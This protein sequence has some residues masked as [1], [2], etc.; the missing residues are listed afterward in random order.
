MKASHILL[1]AV[2]VLAVL[3]GSAH[4]SIETT[5]VHVNTVEI[6]SA[7]YNVY[8]MMVTD[9]FQDWSTCL[10]NVTLTT[11]DFYND[12][13]GSDTQPTAAAIALVPALEWDTYAATPS[14]ESVL[15]SFTLDSQFGQNP[16]TTGPPMG[17]TV[18]KAHW[19]DTVTTGPATFRAARL[20]LSS[21]AAGTIGGW[22]DFWPPGGGPIRDIFDGRYTIIG[23]HIVPEPATLALL[24]LAPLAVLRRRSGQVLRRRRAESGGGRFPQ[25]I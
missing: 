5:F 1:A 8:D 2:A 17:N 19:F 6:D 23:G 11:G 24:A 4:A 25:I 9:T 7:T 10:L 20:T 3:A 16:D 13:S 22:S 21:D 14:G 18:I 15:A 12:S